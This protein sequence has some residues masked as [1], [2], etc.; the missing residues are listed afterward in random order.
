MA[1][2]GYLYYYFEFLFVLMGSSLLEGNVKQYMQK[3]N[4]VQNNA[5]VRV[6]VIKQIESDLRRLI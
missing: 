3:K 6:I 4:A 5:V 2:P 1:L